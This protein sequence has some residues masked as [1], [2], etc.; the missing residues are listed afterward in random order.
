MKRI[1][2]AIPLAATLALAC[3]GLAHAGQA[4]HVA[5]AREHVNAAVT[6]G[7]TGDSHALVQHAQTALEHA[8]MAYQEKP[9]PDLEKA[10]KSLEESI[11]Q[12][13]AGHADKATEHAKEAVEHINAVKGA[14]GG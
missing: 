13:K 11:T 8:R 2:I 10:I 14:L 1:L 5:Q 3:F 12:G 6:Q 7:Q 4:N 9:V